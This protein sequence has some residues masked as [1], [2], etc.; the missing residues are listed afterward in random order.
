MK[1][2]LLDTLEAVQDGDT[3][4]RLSADLRDLVGAV[5]QSGR[6]AE[7]T[8]KLTLKPDGDRRVKVLVSNTNKPPKPDPEG[9]RFYFTDH[10]GLSV[11]DPD[12]P[13]LMDLRTVGGEK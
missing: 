13:T 6:P 3:L 8:L 12:Q 4:R 2:L 7:M 9:S 10:N 11:S 5:R 1:S